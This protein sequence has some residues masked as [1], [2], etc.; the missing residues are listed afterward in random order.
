[1]AL[2]EAFLI[3]E[4]TGD[5]VAHATSRCS[6]FP[7][8]DPIPEPPEDPPVVDQPLPGASPDHP[9][10]RPLQGGALPQEVWSG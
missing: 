1:M 4:S 7:P 6:I 10:R 2:S 9:L 3:N 5:L 8:V